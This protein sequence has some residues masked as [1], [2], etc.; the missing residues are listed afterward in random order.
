LDRI[1]ALLAHVERLPGYAHDLKPV[2]LIR[3]NLK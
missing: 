2:E 1:P 3:G